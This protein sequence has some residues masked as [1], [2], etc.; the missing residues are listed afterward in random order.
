MSVVIVPMGKIN[1][2][3]ASRALFNR[4]IMIQAW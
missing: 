1:Y 2:I 4:N 3:G